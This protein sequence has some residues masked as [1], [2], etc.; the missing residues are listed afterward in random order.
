MLLNYFG[1]PTERTYK[2]LHKQIQKM[3]LFEVAPPPNVVYEGKM[4]IR[5]HQCFETAQKFIR[6]NLVNFLPMV[7]VYCFWSEEPLLDHAFV[8][9][10]EQI[11]YDGVL[12]K[13]YNKDDYY[14]E[15]RIVEVRRKTPAQVID[16]HTNSFDISQ[17]DWTARLKYM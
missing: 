1:K 4:G 3:K 8:L 15:C 5:P 6:A 11:I 14:R 10:N 2:I 13:F 16:E 7:Y 12:N 9:I 17:K